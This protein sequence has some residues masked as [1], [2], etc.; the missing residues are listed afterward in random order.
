MR[1]EVLVWRTS[2]EHSL[3]ASSEGTNSVYTN[4]DFQ[5]RAEDFSIMYDVP[6]TDALDFLHRMN[7][8]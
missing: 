7:L 6:D 2:S 3:L 4:S 8:K 5:N 1:S